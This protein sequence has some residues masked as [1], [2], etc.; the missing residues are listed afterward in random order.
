[1]LHV[2]RVGALAL[3]TAA[4]IETDLIRSEVVRPDV[5]LVRADPLP[6]G[7]GHVP[8][9]LP[10]IAWRLGAVCAERGIDAARVSR[11]LH[12]PLSIA[13][14][15]MGQDVPF[16]KRR[17]IAALCGWACSPPICW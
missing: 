2:E 6:E 9:P 13:E 10:R 17:H 12:V 8:Q 14:Q 15:L 7:E 1:M 5:Y 16:I 11:P 4:Q 3:V